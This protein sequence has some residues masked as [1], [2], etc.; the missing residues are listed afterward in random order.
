MRYARFL[1]L[2]SAIGLASTICLAADTTGAQDATKKAHNRPAIGQIDTNGDGKVSYEELKAKFPR[3]TEEKFRA[4]D[5]NGDGFLTPDE[6]LGTEPNAKSAAKPAAQTDS[7]R[8]PGQLFK[9]SDADANG[10]VTLEEV[11][12]IAPKFPE[13]RFK[14]LDKNGDGA[15]S[16]EEVPRARP[17]TGAPEKPGIDA[18]FA[19]A[20]NDRDGKVTFEELGVVAPKITK[21][22]FAKLDKNSDGALTK[23]E[24]PRPSTG[25][26]EQ[27]V[28]LLARKA[29][30][31]H[32]GKVTYEEMLAVTP[33]LTR[34]R[35]D[36]MDTNKD[37]VLSP[38]DRAQAQ[39]DS[40]EGVD[41]GV[42]KLMACDANSD[43]K[44]TFEELTTAK[45]GFPREAF[46][47]A[48]QNKDGVI[49]ADDAKK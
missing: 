1:S 32:N 48:D 4:R 7:G 11:H 3:V 2:A 37:G 6:H 41:D 21:E 9:Q 33:N 10:Q 16:G 26:K 45:P 29:D 42:K 36:R 14:E 40:K 5:N 22:K 44:V 19:R 12:A 27:A 8:Q 24:L 18:L 49:S 20:D 39:K 23:D 15:I 31:D 17:Q 38:D 25:E 30:A 34:E 46:D 47:R 35:F 43:G 13:E 28:A